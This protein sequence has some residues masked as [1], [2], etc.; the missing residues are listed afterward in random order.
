MKMEVS[1][2]IFYNPSC[3][4]R[5]SK[6]E[7]QSQFLKG[8]IFCNSYKNVRKE[9][10]QKDHFQ[11]FLCLILK[12]MGKKSSELLPRGNDISIVRVWSLRLA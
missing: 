4:D 1:C 2:R 8:L 5:G 9:R 10:E 11:R 3:Q 12:K 6:E 7:F